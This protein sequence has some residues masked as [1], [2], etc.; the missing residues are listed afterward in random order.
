MNETF[1]SG[2]IIIRDKEQVVSIVPY[3]QRNSINGLKIL[4]FEHGYEFDGAKFFDD[5]RDIVG[6]ILPNEERMVRLQTK[7]PFLHCEI[8]SIAHALNP[9]VIEPTSEKK[10]DIGASVSS[11]SADDYYRIYSKTTCLR[12][13]IM[14][15]DKHT[16]EFFNSLNNDRLTVIRSEDGFDSLMFSRCSLE[17]PEFNEFPSK[18]VGWTLCNDIP[19][20]AI[21][22]NHFFDGHRTK[23]NWDELLTSGTCIYKERCWLSIELLWML[24]NDDFKK[25][26]KPRNYYTKFLGTEYILNKFDQSFLK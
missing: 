11:S 1:P 17:F 5:R 2:K 18:R 19:I 20:V 15:E 23:S 7:Y 22:Q 8:G 14:C 26:L 21:Q 9:S 3:M 13:I 25:W 10:Y 24:R 12:W 4:F 16:F 6:I